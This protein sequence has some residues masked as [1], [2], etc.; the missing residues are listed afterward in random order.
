MIVQSQRQTECMTSTHTYECRHSQMYSKSTHTANTCTHRCTQNPSTQ[1]THADTHR[2]TQIHPHSKHMQTLT[3]VLKSI[4]TANTYTHRCTQ[5]H[6]HSKHMQTL[7][8]VLKSIHIANTYRHR[9]TQIH[10]HSKHMQTLTMYSNPSTQQTHA[11]T[12]NVLKSIHTANMQTL[13]MY[14]NPFTQQPHMQTFTD[15]LKFIHTVT[16][17]ADF[18]RCTQIHPHSN[19]MQLN[20]CFWGHL[21]FRA[22]LT[23]PPISN[24]THHPHQ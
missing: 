7:T 18:H 22:E 17:H 3:D 16:T 20:S 23:H 19:H 5:I 1:Q 10:P 12:H 13:T 14:S 11:D 24:H 6:P 15:V 4:H 9:C 2:C 21:C 8:D